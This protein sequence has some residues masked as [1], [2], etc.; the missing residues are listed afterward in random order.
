[1]FLLKPS[2]DD[3]VQALSLGMSYRTAVQAKTL[4]ALI[5]LIALNCKEVRLEGEGWLVH[6]LR[7]VQ[8]P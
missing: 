1:M 5:V 8:L 3:A 7:I 2:Y 4:A 6:Q